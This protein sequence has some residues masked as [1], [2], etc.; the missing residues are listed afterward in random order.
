MKLA[1]HFLRLVLSLSLLVGTNSFACDEH[2]NSGFTEENDMWIATDAKEQSGITEENFNKVID[3]VS[4]IYA[5]IVK[6]FGAELRVERK[7]EDGT[8]NAYAQRQGNVWMVSMFGGLA[9][10][11]ETT[12]DGFALVMCHE[13]GHHLGGVPKKKGWFSGTTWASNEG[14]SDYWGNMK[15]IRRLFEKDNNIEVISKMEIPAIVKEK[16]DKSFSVEEESAICQRA[17]MAGLSLGRLLGALSRAAKVNFDT[18]DRSVAS[19]TNHNHPAAQC[20]LDT[21]FSAA[22]CDVDFRV[23]VNSDAAAGD[24]WT[25]ACTEKDKHT[26]G[27]RPACWFNAKK[28]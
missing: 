16:C 5:P 4:A 23:D 21:Y 6:E 13:L 3:D 25:G 20:R 14:Q 28:L 2:G 15:C 1:R 19:T 24:Y 11:Q 26:V 18:P 7:W 17:G 9:R 22:I 27:L 8:V 12:V 10:H